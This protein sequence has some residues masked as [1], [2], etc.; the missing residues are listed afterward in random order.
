MIEIET[1]VNG[2]LTPLAG[3]P[4]ERREKSK[5]LRMKRDTGNKAYCIWLLGDS[6]PKNW[7]SILETPFDPR[8]PARHSIWTPVV[9]AIQDQVFR[10]LRARIGTSQLYIR[11]AIENPFAKPKPNL[12]EWPEEV[13]REIIKFRKMVE[14]YRPKLLCSFGAFAFEFGR[15]VLNEELTRSYSY[16]GAKKLGFEFRNRIENFDVGKTNLIPLLHVS[17]ARGRFI[18]SHD[19]FCNKDGANYFEYVGSAIAS[20]LIDHREDFSIWI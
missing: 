10:E 15:R 12:K 17:I 13:S 8:H 3:V 20:E 7:A 9:D 16:W 6:N 19:Y 18:Q 14:K 1:K 2:V 11:N 4:G 5:S